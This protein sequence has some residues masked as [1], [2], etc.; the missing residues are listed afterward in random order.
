M[1]RRLSDERLEA[2]LRAGV[3][4]FALRGREG[5]N[6]RA[7]A[8]RAGISVGALYKYYGGKERLFEACLSRSLEALR[9][10]LAHVT[11]EPAGFQEYARRII[12]ALLRFSQEHGAYVRLY[13]TLAAAGG[14]EA[15]ALAKEIEGITAV[16]YTRTIAAGQAAGDLRQD[17]DPA[18]FALLFDS[19]LMMVQFSG[20]C[21][22][23]RARYRLY[24][25]GELTE[26]EARME[27]ELLKFL[28]SAFT[29]SEAEVPHG[30]RRGEEEV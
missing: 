29:F 17:M 27:R 23:Y 30:D 25:G 10:A 28:T 24:C 13:C 5:A 15:A 4:E 22:Y 6:M 21:D 2:L 7:I 9:E 12:R 14:P 20:C 1:L 26:Q 16:L 18:V 8:D 3:E 11:A 19:L